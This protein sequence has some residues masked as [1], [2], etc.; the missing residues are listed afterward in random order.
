MIV[1]DTSVWIDLFVNRETETVLKLQKI[2]PVDLIVVDLVA[3]EV[4]QGVRTERQARRIEEEFRIFGI[5]PAC[6]PD[7]AIK[8]AGNYRR[9]RSRGITIR[10]TI[11]LIIG[12]FCIENGH[13]LLHADR[14][15]VPMAEHLGLV[16]A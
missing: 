15:F 8:A 9:L 16:L 10:K 13:A 5:Q 6:S 1:V 4:L 2:D 3:V 11:D 12:T 7:L 14:D